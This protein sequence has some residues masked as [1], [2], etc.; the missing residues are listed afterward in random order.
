M[1]YPE[2]SLNAVMAVVLIAGTVL[3]MLQL[4]RGAIP[5]EN[6]DLFNIALGIWLTW[7]SMAVK[8]LFEGS[9]SSD[10]KNDTIQSQAKALAA[11]PGDPT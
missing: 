5:S 10:Q 7:G 9:A 3:I 4:G 2:I 11:K 1:K 6:R 8:R